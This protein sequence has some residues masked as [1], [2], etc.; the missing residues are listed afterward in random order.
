M[1]VMVSR[2]ERMDE[3]EVSS[4]WETQSNR[5]AINHS[6][7]IKSRMVLV[8]FFLLQSKLVFHKCS[9]PL[10]REAFVL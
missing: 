8:G 7:I 5:N 9:H 10:F 4:K 2:S 1:K 6:K 3:R